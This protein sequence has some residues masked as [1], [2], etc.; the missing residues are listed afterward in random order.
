[1]SVSPV[2]RLED[3][4]ARYELPLFIVT[5]FRKLL[6]KDAESARS[7]LLELAE[8]AGVAEEIRDGRAS[9]PSRTG[10]S[11]RAV[12]DY[13]VSIGNR[14][15]TKAEIVDATGVSEHT[16]HTMLYR[17]HQSDF[18]A[19]PNPDGGRQKLYRLSEN[20]SARAAIEDSES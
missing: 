1:M 17:S 3:L 6:E 20:P 19:V 5:K 7:L 9:P 15:L 11:F 14:A 4:T 8:I 16:I 13:L 12:Q 10:E 2:K 18:E